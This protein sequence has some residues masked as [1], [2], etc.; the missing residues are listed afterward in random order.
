M[1]LVAMPALLLVAVSPARAETVAKA[2]QSAS[3]PEPVSVSVNL[4]HGSCWVADSG[5]SYLGQAPF[6]VHLSSTAGELWRSAGGAYAN[7]VSISVNPTDGSC[8]MSCQRSL[9]SVNDSQVVHLSSTG[10][11]LG[12]SA[13][14]EFS[15][16]GAI[17][18][19]AADG[20][21]VRTVQELLGHADLQTTAGYLHS[22]TRTKQAAVGRLAAAFADAATTQWGGGPG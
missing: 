16:P 14:G 1:W 10:T 2:W 13:S 12:I 7:P 3:V 22:D 5:D 4:T 9:A 21:D 19:N 8:W 11:V 6:V 17:A 15:I 20:V 18:A